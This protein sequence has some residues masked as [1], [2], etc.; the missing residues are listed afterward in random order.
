MQKLRFQEFD[1]I[2]GILIILV[3]LG[4]T[5]FVGKEVIYWFHMPLFFLISGFFFKKSKSLEELCN[6]FKLRLKK[7]LRPYFCYLL[8]LSLILY[9]C[10]IIDIDTVFLVKAL[11]GGKALHSYFAVFWFITTLLF[12][13]LFYSLIIFYF[14]ESTIYFILLMY[15]ISMIQYFF[16]SKYN[17]TYYVPFNIDSSFFAIIFFH[18][19]YVFNSIIKKH[20]SS[21]FIKANRH[22]LITFFVILIII[23]LFQHIHFIDIKYQEYGLVFINIVIPLIF[24][25]NLFFLSNRIKKKFI[26]QSIFLCW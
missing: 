6:S 17:L 16:N 3:V 26:R 2:K 13:N 1:I 4:H 20:N 9:A 21:F 15:L 23:Y 12:T 25:V 22:I 24:F 10:K 7:Y 5:N 14:K 19:G 8:I 18:I 11:I